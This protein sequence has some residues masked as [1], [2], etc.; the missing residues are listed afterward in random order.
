MHRRRRD[1]HTLACSAG[2]PPSTGQWC[3][4]RPRLP[5]PQ[6]CARL[7]KPSGSFTPRT[8]SRCA[9]PPL[10]RRC[11]E[12][13]APAC[14]AALTE[15]AQPAAARARAPAWATWAAPSSLGPGGGTPLP[16]IILVMLVRWTAAA[17]SMDGAWCQAAACRQ[18]V[19]SPPSLS[20]LACAPQMPTHSEWLGAG[21]PLC[22]AH[23]QSGEHPRLVRHKCLPHAC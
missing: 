2:R 15:E 3:G 22:C 5:L 17:A 6:S 18:S 16:G 19:A 10:S 20:A 14:T 9:P 7:S 23:R 8:R 1:R 21:A 13:R 11:S 12:S 4:P